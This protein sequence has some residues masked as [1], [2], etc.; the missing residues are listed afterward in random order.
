MP[1]R[2]FCAMTVRRRE[3]QRFTL[4][5]ISVRTAAHTI[6][7]CYDGYDING[8]IQQHCQSLA[9]RMDQGS[10][11]SRCIMP[12]R[13]RNQ[14]NGDC[15]FSAAALQSAQE[16]HSALLTIQNQPKMIIAV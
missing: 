16:R 3:R 10:S 8:R 4:C 13:Q 5:T 2:Q 14:H 15:S 1:C 9:N 11:D 7:A 12:A 6:H